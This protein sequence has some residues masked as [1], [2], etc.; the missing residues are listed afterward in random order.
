MSDPVDRFFAAVSVLAAHG[1]IKQRL[2][3]AYEENLAELGE[4]E[5]P[6]AVRETFADL[7]SQMDRVPPLNG[8]GPVCATVRKMSVDEAS[9][10]AVSVVDLWRKVMAA[11]DH[12]PA[13]EGVERVG[14]QPFLVKT[15]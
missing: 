10:C 7:K 2:I 8:E 12:A 3:K 15:S 5:L 13:M 9:A 14:T 1:H 6:L 4:H 11:Q